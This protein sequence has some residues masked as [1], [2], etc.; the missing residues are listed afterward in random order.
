MKNA[1]TFSDIYQ[2]LTVVV[3]K[4]ENIISTKQKINELLNNAYILK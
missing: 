2:S 1:F 4:E 3:D